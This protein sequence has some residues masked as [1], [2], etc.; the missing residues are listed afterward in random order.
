MITEEVSTHKHQLLSSVKSSVPLS[1]KDRYVVATDQRR[2]GQRTY[3]LVDQLNGKITLAL[4]DIGELKDNYAKI[5]IEIDKI[6]QE[7]QSMNTESS[8]IPNLNGSMDFFGWVFGLSNTGLRW[9]DRKR[10]YKDMRWGSNFAPVEVHSLSQFGL[11]FVSK[12]KAI[13]PFGYIVPNSV[14]SYRGRRFSGNQYF[15]ITVI[16]YNENKEEIKRTLFNFTE[17]K[18]YEAFTFKIFKFIK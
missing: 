10:W 12:G 11:K 15:N 8:V 14:Y 3:I 9:G 18:Q 7:V 5:E 2:E 1:N 13:S 6:N 16:E 17:P 4:E